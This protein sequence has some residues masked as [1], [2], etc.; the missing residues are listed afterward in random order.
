M[1]AE[2]DSFFMQ[3]I[4][5]RIYLWYNGVAYGMSFRDQA[6]FGVI[7]PRHKSKMQNH[8]RMKPFAGSKAIFYGIVL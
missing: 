4:A 3:L 6:E 8:A 2:A 7:G 5:K 1:S